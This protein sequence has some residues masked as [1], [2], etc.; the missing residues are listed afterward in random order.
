MAISFYRYLMRYRDGRSDDPFAIFAKNAY[1]DHSFP[2]SSIDYDEISNYLELNADYLHN[3]S[4][5][6]QLWDLY[7][8]DVALL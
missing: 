8:H 1:E 7:V 2:K 3:M 6:D 5:F 4:V